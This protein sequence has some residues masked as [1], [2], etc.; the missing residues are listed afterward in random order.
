LIFVSID[1]KPRLIG[2]KQL[3]TGNFA[4][5][6]E[7]VVK[8][9]ALATPQGRDATIDSS[10]IADCE[11]M[12]E[13]LSRVGDKWTV[14]LLAVLGDKRMRFKDLHRA[15]GGIS[16]RML[17]V[18][19]KNLERDGFMTRIVHPTIPP[20]VEYELSECGQSL[21]R[22]LKPIGEWVKAN[23]SAIEKSRRSF[24]RVANSPV[25]DRAQM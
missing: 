4:D 8:R 9:E 19:L 5:S 13:V 11:P 22:V 15:M 23:W 25:E 1:I 14:V 17:I 3:F 7:V 18:T 21:R 20:K 10:T 16:Q 24:D 12:R 6:K 2:S